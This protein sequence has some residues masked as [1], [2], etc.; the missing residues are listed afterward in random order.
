MSGIYEYIPRDKFITR[1]ELVRISG[2]SDR[3]VRREINE[4]RKSPETVIISSSHRKGYKRPSC[5]EEIELCLNESKSRVRDEI[6][7][8][9]VLEKAMRDFKKNEINGQLLFDF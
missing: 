2:F 6:E 5:I 1:E 7:K 4:L 9:R 8:Q 3:E